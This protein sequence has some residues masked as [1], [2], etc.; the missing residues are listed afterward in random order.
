MEAVY[1]FL[2]VSVHRHATFK[3]MQADDGMVPLELPLQSDT[4]WVCKHRAVK[5]FVSRF[6]CILSTMRKLSV[7]DSPRERAEA[8]GL[9]AL[10]SSFDNLFVLHLLDRILPIINS[11]STFL[12]SK[13]G[14]AAKVCSL[15]NATK[16]ALLEMR[17]DDAFRIVY[18]NVVASAHA[19]AISLPVSESIQGKTL[20]GQRNH[21]L[22]R[23]LDCSV[24][25]CSAGYRES[26]DSSHNNW[27]RDMFE[28]ID[29]M[30][31]DM[32]RR[33]S[34]NEPFLN[35]ETSQNVLAIHNDRSKAQ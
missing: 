16:Q 2:T 33:F 1:C 12:Q 21:A 34:S 6:H 15:V 23:Q 4:R 3:Q 20:P 14:D 24:V 27:K 28:I 11:L 18:E 30:T 25:I 31:G 26:T 8:K 5:V 10:L 35:D 17:T 32:D 7:S 29:K 19:N 9:V 22:P 13:S